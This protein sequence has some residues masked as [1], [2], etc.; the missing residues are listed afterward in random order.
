[1]DDI[2]AIPIDDKYL[3]YAPL[4]HLTAL[5]NRPALAQLEASLQ[6]D[7]PAHPA[8]Q[9][10]VDRLRAPGEPVPMARTGPLT[11]PLFL[12]IIPTRGCNMACR[13]C[14]FAAPKQSSPVMS[15]DLARD[16]VDAYFDLLAAAGQTR[17]EVHFFGGEPFC[18]ETAVHFVVEYAAHRAAEHGI[19]MRFE[20]TSN[21]LYPAARGQWIADHFDTLVLSL[22]GPAEIQNAHR[23]TPNGHDSF[24]IVARSAAIFSDAPIELVIRACITQETVGRM[25][26]IA[27]WITHEFLPGSVCFE[28]LTLSPL[29]EQHEMLPPDPWEFALN[30]DRAA[31]ILGAH[32]IETVHSTA[33]TRDCRA[34]FCPVGRDALIVSPDGWVDACYLLHEDWERSG[35]NLRI[36]RLDSGR[37]AIHT[38]ALQDVRALTVHA[39]P[40]CADCFCRYHCAGGCHVN[41]DTRGRPGE[42][43]ALCVQTRLIT[44][45]GL[46]REIGQGELAA[47]WLEDRAA[48]AV[49]AGQPSDRLSR[50]E[51]V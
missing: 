33:S 35:L 12:G 18:A 27:A 37:F 8:L 22:D 30:F 28:T 46:L 24:E 9:P 1:M 25:P 48:C 15:L 26:E 29:A 39:R 5:V 32:G 47:A 11:D 4:H 17:G 45:A 23:P 34:T 20:A 3:L 38:D 40:L 19:A 7:A 50:I 51:A 14:D 21:G 36:G 2:F 16:A 10:L 41:H 31:Q 13:Y 49:S 42:Y 6:A 44:L 43:D